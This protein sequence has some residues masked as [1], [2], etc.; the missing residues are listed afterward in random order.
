MVGGMNLPLPVF[1]LLFRLLPWRL[2]LPVMTARA[3]LA[4]QTTILVRAF[5]YES[6]T[7][8]LVF[9]ALALTPQPSR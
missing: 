4:S 7:E 6:Q 2:I 1:C 9:S 5:H 8:A 3:P